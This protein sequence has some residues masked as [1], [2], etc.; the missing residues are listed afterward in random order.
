MILTVLSMAFVFFND[1]A[2]TEI[3]TLALH[4]A[5]PIYV[6]F[7]NEDRAPLLFIAGSEDN[8]MPPAVNQSNAKHY[9][10]VKSVTDYKEFPGR[11]SEEHTSELQSRQYLVC[12]L[13]LEK[14]KI[15]KDRLYTLF[16]QSPWF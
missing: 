8:I 12:R 5:L 11:R 1:T 14:K 7:R 10:H 2:T 15:I 4:D 3:Y 16:L 6:D 9:R 13:L